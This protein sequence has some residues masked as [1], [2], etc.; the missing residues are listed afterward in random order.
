METHMRKLRAVIIALLLSGHGSV[1]AG[2]DE[3]TE[4][5][6]RGDYVTAAKEYRPLA[7][8]GHAV[9]QC[10]LGIL[11]YAGQG[12][13]QD[14]GEAAK[15]YRKSA[16]QGNADAQLHLGVMYHEG[17]SVSQDY[18]EAAKWYRKSAAQGNADAQYNLGILYAEG[19]G[20]PQDYVQAHMWFNIAGANGD[21]AGS[22]SRDYIASKMTPAQITE[23][24]KLAREWME[25]HP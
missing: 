23:A 12:V 14:Y 4:A 3:A 15:W 10:N 6:S 20:V 1:M 7:E 8:Q 24:K 18:G 21:K 5:V 13:P 2:W 16:A 9:A 19:Q 11:Y 25:K 17:Q 22:K